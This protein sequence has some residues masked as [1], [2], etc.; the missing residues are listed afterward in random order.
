MMEARPR[1]FSPF[2]LDILLWY[3]TRCE[4]HEAMRRASSWPETI[5]KFIEMGLMR[6][7]SEGERAAATVLG[8]G[9]P[10]KFRMTDKGNVYVRDGL[11]TVPL[12]EQVW[13]I[14][15]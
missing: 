10:P 12:P 8:A 1:V 2:E 4:D 15:Q 7:T 3:H 6:P 5:H 13:V 11:C 9:V 14:P